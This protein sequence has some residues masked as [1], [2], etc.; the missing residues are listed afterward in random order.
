[1][2][3][4]EQCVE[5][6]LIEKEGEMVAKLKKSKEK[7]RELVEKGQE[8]RDKELMGMHPNEIDE[9]SA[10]NRR[11]KKEVLRKIQKEQTRNH[12]FHYMT[13]HV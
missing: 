5:T 13:K 9:D 4:K 6:N 3:N 11:R 7:F 10:A 8:Q 12:E 2:E 1:M